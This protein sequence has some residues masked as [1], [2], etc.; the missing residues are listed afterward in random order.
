[1]RITLLDTCYLPATVDGAAAGGR[2][3]PV[4]RR[5]VDAW[6][7][8]VDG[9]QPGAH[10]AHRRG[11]ALASA[12]CRPTSSQRRG[13]ATATGAPLHVHLSEQRAENEACLA[14]YGCTPTRLLADQGR[15]RPWTTA[16]HAT[17]LTDDDIALLGDSRTAVCFCPTTERDLADGIG[18]AR[19]LA[20]AGSPLCLGSDSHAVIDLF[21]E[22][23]AAGDCTSGCA[24]SAGA[25]SPPPSCW[26]PLTAHGHAALGWPEAGRLAAGARADLVA[27]R[28]TR[29]A[30]PAAAPT[31]SSSAPTASDVTDVVVGG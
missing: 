12:P 25:T 11:H 9:L 19:A 28:W 21:E 22:A 16:V 1:M 29:C 18:P 23:R 14:A 6:A 20:D 24:P 4:R 5:H 26:T 27:V 30:P 3:A 2:P 31:R 15:A 17:H 10:A 13:L 8:R 7:D